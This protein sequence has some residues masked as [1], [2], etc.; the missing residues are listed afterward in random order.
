MIPLVSSGHHR[1]LPD[2]GDGDY[3]DDD[4]IGMRM[5]EKL[6]VENKYCVVPYLFDLESKNLPNHGE[7][8]ISCVA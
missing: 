2:N 7:N 1:R 6:H 3:N 4:E 5:K 8:C